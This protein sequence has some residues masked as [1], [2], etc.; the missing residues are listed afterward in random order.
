MNYVRFITAATLVSLACVQLPAQA[1][2]E[3]T[4]LEEVLSEAKL[5]KINQHETPVQTVFNEFEENFRK[6]D[7]KEF[8]RKV[9]EL[10]FPEAPTQQSFSEQPASMFSKEQ[11]EAFVSTVKELYTESMNQGQA[12][13]QQGADFVGS[14]RKEF[15]EKFTQLTKDNPDYYLAAKGV[16]GYVVIGGI[17]Y[18]IYK[19][20]LVQAIIK[21]SPLRLR[22]TL[23]VT[24]G[25]IG[26]AALV[27]AINPEFA[28]K[29][30]SNAPAFTT[31]L[32]SDALASLSK[33]GSDLMQKLP[34]I[35]VDVN[36]LTKRLM[37]A[38][39]F[40]QE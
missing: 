23:A 31:K 35:T 24:A 26:A 6:C 38:F 19:T 2:G 40:T 37:G 13:Y 18:A 4:V 39:S 14:L 32:A 27:A 20:G 15:G 16:V 30:I 5:E 36:G 7:G 25:L 8:S 10:E 1:E 21:K 3:K 29:V 22:S 17:C 12:L 11:Y 28:T 9:S 34:T 33:V